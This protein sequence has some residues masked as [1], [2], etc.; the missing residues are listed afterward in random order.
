MLLEEANNADITC[1]TQDRA[2]ASL[3]R[4]SFSFALKFWLVRKIEREV[5]RFGG[6]SVSAVYWCFA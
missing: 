6:G 4:I 1:S 3:S 2:I 5:G